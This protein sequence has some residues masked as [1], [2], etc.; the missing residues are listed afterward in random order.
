MG[1]FQ[2]HLDPLASTMHT[3][4]RRRQTPRL[5]TRK[6]SA[7][8]KRCHSPVWISQRPQRAHV[9]THTLRIR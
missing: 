3:D 5:T 2:S 4:K 1:P 6:V 7:S 9:F 8:Q